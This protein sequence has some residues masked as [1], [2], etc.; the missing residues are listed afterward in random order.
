M[1]SDHPWPKQLVV[2]AFAAGLALLFQACR[3]VP[4]PRL[5]ATG[6]SSFAFIAPASAQP[7]TAP[8]NGPVIE[9]S[10]EVEPD[11]FVEAK[12]LEPLTKP[13][14][15]PKALSGKAGLVTVGVRVTIDAE[16]HVVDVGPSLLT[17]SNPSRYAEEFQAA[18]RSAVMQWRFR[19]AQRSHGR[20]SQSSEGG[21]TAKEFHWE[22]TET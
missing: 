10:F 9:D 8:K 22:N 5:S 17:F 20:A 4:G 1:T 3:Q 13:V 16:G 11:Y 21:G 19:P 18:V 7:R 6:T 15:P 14:Y 2:H 12:P